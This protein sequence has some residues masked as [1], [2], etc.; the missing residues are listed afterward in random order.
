MKLSE[1]AI[2]QYATTTGNLTARM[3][4]HAYGTNPQTW[5][6]WLSER[7]PVAGD[8]L[9]VGAG[10]GELWRHV[11]HSRARLTLADFSPAMC[12]RLRAIPGA[13]VRQCDAAELPFA[14]ASF[15]CLIAD[16]MLYHVDD[17]ALVLQEFARVLRSGGRLAI[18][19]NGPGHM[20]E[21]DT[22]AAALGRPDIE[23]MS[24]QS[25]VN[26][27]TAPA[28][29]ARFFGAVGVERYD[30]D[31]AIPAAEPVLAYLAS[32]A[33]QPLTPAEEAAARRAV[34]DRLETDGSFTVHKDTSLITAVRY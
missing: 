32:M 8:V 5:F 20:A 30:C 33:E 15:D 1:R 28:L 19:L 7:L 23:R 18:A 3:A 4:I 9:E 26:S 14:D 2:H 21:V 10:T 17:P 27:D 6:A 24:P 22:L 16:H 29:I 12:D 31:L 11:D 34:T 13:T 25:A